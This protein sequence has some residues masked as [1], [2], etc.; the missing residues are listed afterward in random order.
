MCIYKKAFLL[1]SCLFFKY[2]RTKRLC[3]AFEA[4]VQTLSLSFGRYEFRTLRAVAG[5]QGDKLEKPV[6][7]N[8][9]FLPKSYS[10]SGIFFS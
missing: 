10:M 9:V 7:G 4:R 1:S 5:I 3:V 8:Q 6:M 2:D